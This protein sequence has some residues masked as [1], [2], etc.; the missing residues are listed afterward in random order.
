MDNQ[1]EKTMSFLKAK[2]DEIP[3][4]PRFEKD[5]YNNVMNAEEKV[6][7]DALTIFLERT[8]TLDDYKDC[9]R[10][11]LKGK[12]NEYTFCHKHIPI[13]VIKRSFPSFELGDNLSAK[14][15]ITVTFTPIKY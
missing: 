10:I 7:I 3:K 6:L 12:G 14:S 9:E 2:F 13:G 11:F 5:F 8:P 4:L 1:T 15:H